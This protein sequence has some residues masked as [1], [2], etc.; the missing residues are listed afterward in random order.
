ML[1][2]E[3][4]GVQNE[5]GS[6]S[7]VPPV[8][9][10]VYAAIYNARTY[11]V[12]PEKVGTGTGS[13][14]DP[15]NPTQAMTNPVAGEIC[16]WLEGIATGTASGLRYEP[17]FNPANSGTSGN[18]IVHIAKNPACYS[19]TGYTELRSGGTVVGSGGPAFGALA[20]DYIS[21]MGFYTN[22]SSPNNTGVGDSGTSVIW[23]STGSVMAYC[24]FLGTNA[25]TNDNHAA[26]R[27]E[28][29]LS[30]HVHNNYI[31]GYKYD[32]GTG[33]TN[34]AGIQ[35]Y[36][37]SLTI[38]EHNEIIDCADAFHF[39][40]R[41]HYGNTIRFNKA[42]TLSLSFAR[43]GGFILGPQGE[44][45]QIYQNL[46]IGA[47]YDFEIAHSASVPAAVTGTDIFNNTSYATTGISSAVGLYFTDVSLG[48]GNT[49][50][51][52]IS[53]ASGR[54]AHVGTE[55]S[56]LSAQDLVDSFAM[57]YNC[58]FAMTN[59]A[60]GTSSSD[61]N[62]A[63]LATWQSVTTADDNSINADPLFVD[64]SADDFRLNTGS[65]CLLA[66]DAGQ[67]M[68]CYLTGNEEIGIEVEA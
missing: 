66:G 19:T 35:T 64:P 68:G 44:R 63:S 31:N 2:L 4:T 53:Y 54:K 12:D 65:P 59:W 38:F 26:V 11:T 15:F 40:G 56:W 58:A 46:T 18:N 50:K 34:Q 67:N 9:S 60:D 16:G 39:K 51:N 52:N 17:S 57:D 7:S 37:T 23:T 10:A 1:N 27:T 25:P 33:S 20:K 28:N 8:A 32:T 13:D 36:E 61:F 29:C 22:E 21:W 47:R 5:D 24:K 41:D 55:A 3:F 45:N 14:A 43:I 6:Y 42:K 30:A 48:A 49:Y 62:D